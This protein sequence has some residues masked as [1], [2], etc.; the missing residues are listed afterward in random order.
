MIT[1][2]TVGP[3]QTLPLYIYTSIKLG[4]TPEVNAVATVILV[5]TLGVFALGSLLLRGGRRFRRREGE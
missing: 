5:A 2:F 3:Q 1:F 4:V